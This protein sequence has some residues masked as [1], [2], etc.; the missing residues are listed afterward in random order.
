MFKICLDKIAVLNPHVQLLPSSR[1]S[2]LVVTDSGVLY[3]NTPHPNYE[4][5]IEYNS[6][7][8]MFIH[9]KQ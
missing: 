4:I 7:L 1:P 5:Y 3:F 8:T 2:S 9:T 6:L